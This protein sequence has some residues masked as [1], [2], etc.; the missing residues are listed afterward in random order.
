M[1]GE[2]MEPLE[3]E[4]A[5]EEL[6]GIV[7]KLEGGNLPLEEALSLFE[8]GIKLSKY[9]NQKLDEAEKKVEILLRDENGKLS[10]EPFEPS[11]KE[12]S[13]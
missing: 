9:C 13:P 5:I 11:L 6:K 12:E 4:K 8:K 3:F 10:I 1:I 2:K 7:S